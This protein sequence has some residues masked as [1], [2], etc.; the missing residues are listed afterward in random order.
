MIEKLKIHITTT[1]AKWVKRN[2]GFD[3]YEDENYVIS[4]E[5]KK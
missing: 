2:L 3:P 5:F 4:E 1:E